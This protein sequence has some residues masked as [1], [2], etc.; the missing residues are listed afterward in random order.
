VDNSLITIGGQATPP[1]QDHHLDL[2]CLSQPLKMMFILILFPTLICRTFQEFQCSHVLSFF[3]AHG[4]ELN[5]R[6]LFPKL[7]WA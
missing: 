2:V 7:C 5:I 4:I 6:K 3:Y 1:S